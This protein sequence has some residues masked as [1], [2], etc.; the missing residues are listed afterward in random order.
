MVLSG[1]VLSCW[2]FIVYC[3]LWSVAL[4][5]RI[6][7]VISNILPA[8]TRNEVKFSLKIPFMFLAIIKWQVPANGDIFLV[9]GK[10]GD[11]RLAVP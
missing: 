11:C 7:I 9:I 8:S 2:L 4:G 3:D 6:K 10:K 5:P 1:A